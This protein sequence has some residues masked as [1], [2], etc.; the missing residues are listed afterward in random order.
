M[1]TKFDD[2]LLQANILKHHGR[3]HAAH[4]FL[5][6]DKDDAEKIRKWI[7]SLKITDAKRQLYDTT[8][9]NVLKE[10]RNNP[11]LELDKDEEE[12]YNNLTKKP[13]RCFYLTAAGIQQLGFAAND[14]EKAFIDG[15][16]NRGTLLSDPAP[17]EWQFSRAEEQDISAMILIACGDEAVIKNEVSSIDKTMPAGIKIIHRQKGEVL[18]NEHGIGIEHFGYADGV[19]QP[20]LLGETQ[21][22]QF[23]DDTMDPTEVCLF[24]DPL[25]NEERAMGSYFVFRKLEQNVAA[26]KEAEEGLGL[27]EL[28]GAYIVGRFEDGTPVTKYDEERG[29]TSE[30]QL[31]NDFKYDKDEKGNR[32]PWHA[33]IRA[34]NPRID[35]SGKPNVRIVRRGI[36]YDEDER[37]GRLEYHPTG[38]VGLLFMCFQRSIE[39]QFEVIQQHWANDGNLPN[40]AVGTDG[41]IGQGNNA[42]EQAY[43][44]VWNKNVKKIG[45]NIKGFVTLKGGDYFYAPSISFFKNL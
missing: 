23:W 36:P 21:P 15:M 22:G 40:R 4:L 25:V 30:K 39:E 29:I 14:F 17:A 45:C 3:K 18:R 44:L 16:K 26:F 33:H 32:C 35:I 2:A 10:K 11:D 34:V 9:F 38:D 5:Q 31:D 12:A 27:G 8:I 28:G 41:I 43:P 24:K 19:S 13:V 1:E 20:D 37:G 42:R 6:F 7:S